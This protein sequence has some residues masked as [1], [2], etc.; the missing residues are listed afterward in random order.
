[1]NLNITKLSKAAN[2]LNKKHPQ[3]IDDILLFGSTIR[4]KL[5]P[6]DIDILIIFNKKVD[7]DVEYEFKK[8]IS[9]FIPNLS[10]ISKTINSI[11]DQSFSA[12][13]SVLFE[14]YSLL[15]KEFISNKSGF[16]SYGFF[17]YNTKTLSNTNK[18]R[19]YYALNGR[20][21]SKG[22]ADTQDWFKISDNLIAVPLSG[23]ENAKEFFTQWNIEYIYLPTLIPSRL[24]KKHIIS[25]VR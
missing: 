9:N 5:I 22:I 16:S 25:K 3:L 12:R 19:F 17:I 13:E 14:G 8:Q 20:R 7:K 10:L 18:T 23:I 6:N 11:K 4:G 2:E 15:K 1:M 24:A 21:E